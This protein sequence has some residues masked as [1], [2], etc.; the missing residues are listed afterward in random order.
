MAAPCAERMIEVAVR[1]DPK[2]T[3]TFLGADFKTF[4][5]VQDRHN[6]L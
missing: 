3:A 6:V 5:L 1:M 4:V 2:R